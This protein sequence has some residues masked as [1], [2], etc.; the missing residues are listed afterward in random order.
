MNGSALAVNW[1]AEN[2]NAILEAWYPGEE[3]GA[4]VAET[5]AGANNPAG[6]LPV[7]FYRSADDLPPFNDYSMKGRTYR[8]FTGPALYPFGHGL[9]Y[10]QFAYSNP[11]L[12]APGLAAG[13]PLDVELLNNPLDQIRGASSDFDNQDGDSYYQT[14][15]YGSVR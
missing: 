13:K 6:R 1:A 12:S 4:A 15:L 5:L 10:S 7:T 3:G 2:A 11:K 14:E 9:S 8:Y